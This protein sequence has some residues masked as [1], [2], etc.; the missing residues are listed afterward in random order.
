MRT[1]PHAL[2]QIGDEGPDQGRNALCRTAD[3]IAS[4]CSRPVPHAGRLVEAQQAIPL[5]VGYAPKSIQDLGRP[6]A[7]VRRHV[8]DLEVPSSVFHQDSFAIVHEN[9]NSK[10]GWVLNASPVVFPERRHAFGVHVLVDHPADR[11]AIAP[12]E[13]SSA[14]GRAKG[15]GV[16][17]NLMAL[18]PQG[19]EQ[20]SSAEAKRFAAEPSTQQPCRSGLNIKRDTARNERVIKVKGDSHCQ[21]VGP[22][23]GKRDQSAAVSVEASISLRQAGQYQGAG[24][25]TGLG[26]RLRHL[27]QRN[28]LP[29]TAVLGRAFFPVLGM[30]F[31]IGYS[32]AHQR[33]TVLISG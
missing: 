16:D 23:G 17:P 9:I 24:I 13:K 21:D 10:R 8:D 7:V 14:Q 25:F 6:F 22:T 3:V 29:F 18:L 30:F 31:D 28:R 12:K 33:L 19:P 32:V 5:A 27:A 2:L 26:L 1:L 4:P 11:R 15:R 20:H